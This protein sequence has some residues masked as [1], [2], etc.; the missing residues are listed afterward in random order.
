M[1]LQSLQRLSVNGCSALRRGLTRGGAW[2]RRRPGLAAWVFPP[3]PRSPTRT[4]EE[5]Y[6]EFNHRYFAGFGEQ[7]RML[8][9]R[10]RMAF[11]HALV[12]RHIRPGDHVI[13]LGTGTGVLAAFASRQGAAKVHAIDHSEVLNF[14][15]TLAVQNG[16]ERVEFVPVHS[17]E[18]KL[19]E[20]VDVIL[21]EQMGDFLFDEAMVANVLDLRDRLLRPGGLI[22][23]HRFEL[24]CEPIKVRDERAVPFIWELKVH[25]YDYACLERERP[26]ESDYYNRIG[27]DPALVEH[28]LGEPAPALELDLLTLREADLPKEIR[29]VRTVVNAGRLD[30]FAVYFRTFADA[31]LSLS[32]S[33][34]DPGRAPHWGFRILRVEAGTFA[35]GEVIELTVSAS[36]W[37][38]PDT[39]RWRHERR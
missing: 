9:D 37:A 14:A 25:G 20:R 18:F 33:P 10:P 19:P 39:W 28:F 13:D 23:P 6:R 16:I 35:A 22:L 38:E 36:N 27:G 21:H 12:A 34:L 30:G 15:K 31:D 2:M 8:A 29:I 32:S 1:F 3:A 4:A 5:D 26:Q 7:E 17:R 11:Y 24:F